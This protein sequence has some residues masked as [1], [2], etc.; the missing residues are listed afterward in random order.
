MEIVEI[1]TLIDIT[2]TGVRRVAQGTQQELD[3]Y[4]NWITLNQCIEIRSIISYDF[5]PTVEEVDIKNLGFGKSYKGK[6]R[7]WTW[8]VSPDRAHAFADD[9]DAVGGLINSVDQVPIIKNLTETINIDR[10]V[11]EL[12]DSNLKN[13]IVKLITGND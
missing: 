7:V 10:S 2:N 13:T 6:H 3:Q 9:N 8:R 1:K 4:K 11:F 5:S 12:S